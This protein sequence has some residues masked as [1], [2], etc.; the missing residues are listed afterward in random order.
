MKLKEKY[1]SVLS[2]LESLN[3][4]LT[5][6]GIDMEMRGGTFGLALSY[7][8]RC[9]QGLLICADDID[10]IITMDLLKI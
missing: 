4:E 7:T 5:S 9:V 2:N 10:K 1:N 8:S 6:H 3:N